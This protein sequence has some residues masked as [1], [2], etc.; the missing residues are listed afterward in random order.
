[1]EVVRGR[2]VPDRRPP[3]RVVALA[4]AGTV[5]ALFVLVTAQV[6]LGQSGFKLSGLEA[7][8]E[9]KRLIAEQLSID[10]ARLR[11]PSRIAARATAIGMVPARDVTVIA[12]SPAPA[13]VAPSSVA[14][15]V[16]PSWASSPVRGP[17]KRGPN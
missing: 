11:A 15:P 4:V 9:Q 8:A 1:L 13:G 10:V 2:T 14:G 3:V 7:R 16:V 6:L 17:A 5:V 12:A